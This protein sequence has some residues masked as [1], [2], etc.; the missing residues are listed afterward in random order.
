MR[1]V[2]GLNGALTGE[3]VQDQDTRIDPRTGEVLDRVGGIRP[4]NEES[5]PKVYKAVRESAD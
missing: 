1:E 2:N 5:T 4:E 3:C